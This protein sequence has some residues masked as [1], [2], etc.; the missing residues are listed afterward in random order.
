MELTIK[1]KMNLTSAVNTG[2][3]LQYTIKLRNPTSTSIGNNDYV[4]YVYDASNTLIAKAYDFDPDK[5]M[6]CNLGCSSCN[7]IYTACLGCDTAYTEYTGM[8]FGQ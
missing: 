1:I 6:L 2:T 8:E 7:T 4:T 5:A 3:T